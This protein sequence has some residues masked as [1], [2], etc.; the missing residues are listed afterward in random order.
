[1]KSNRDKDRW[2]QAQTDKQT[3]RQ[4]LTDMQIEVFFFSPL[5]HR[6]HNGKEIVN[7]REGR[8]VKVGKNQKG[9]KFDWY[10]LVF[11]HGRNIYCGWSIYKYIY[12]L[13][14]VNI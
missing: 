9:N 3:K 8:G 12:S 14:L 2:R 11:V 7:L 4:A 13:W 1:M 6:F 5:P 10:F